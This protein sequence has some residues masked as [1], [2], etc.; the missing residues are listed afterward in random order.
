MERNFSNLIK[1]LPTNIE[2]LDVGGWGLEGENTSLALVKHFSFDNVTCLNKQHEVIYE[3]SRRYPNQTFIE[4]EFFE[5]KFDKQYDLVVFDTNCE[6]EMQMWEDM[7]V[8]GDL[9]KPNGYLI[10]YVLLTD[11]YGNPETPQQIR[12]HWKTHWNNEN[13]SIVSVIKKL[14]NTP[15]WILEDA[16]ADDRRSEILWIK[17][18]K[19]DG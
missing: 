2:V 18:R 4:T 19:T 16:I 6:G 7:D 8:I 1:G 14:A 15:G 17:L 5:Y 13:F 9:L 12:N 11:E 10:G 3:Y